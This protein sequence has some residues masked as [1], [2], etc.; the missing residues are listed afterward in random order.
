MPQPNLQDLLGGEAQE[1][2]ADFF[3]VADLAPASAAILEQGGPVVAGFSRA[4]SIGMALPHAVVDQLPNRAERAVAMHYR[5]HAYDV[6]NQRLDQIAS[7]LAARLQRAGY[8][9][10]PIPASQT[11]DAARLR[12]IFSNK[13]AASLSGLGWVGKSCL[14]VTPQA[15]PRARWASVLTAAPL[16]PTGTPRQPECGDCRA[17][18]DACPV[19]AF[20]GRLFSPAEPRELRFDVHRC[21]GYLDEM[22]Q[23]R[24]LSVCGMCLYACPHG[25]DA[26]E[27]LRP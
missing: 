26:S 4:I 5:Q 12:G 6:V 7:R 16:P 17:C 3:G 9:A 19:S 11:V 13:L 10:L 27:R 2:G 22:E 21:K 20:T 14:V 15:G 25:K 18:V 24:G 8:R 23:T 1:A